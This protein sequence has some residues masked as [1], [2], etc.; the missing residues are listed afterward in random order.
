MNLGAQIML[1]LF[2]SFIPLSEL[3]FVFTLLYVLAKDM[4]DA[5][6]HS[7]FSVQETYLWNGKYDFESKKMQ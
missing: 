7:H 3:W 1:Y 4:K 6:S 5:S 2:V